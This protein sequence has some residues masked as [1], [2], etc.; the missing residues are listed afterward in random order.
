M[1][2]NHLLEPAF[3]AFFVSLM[4]PLKYWDGLLWLSFPALA[5]WLILRTTQ[6]R[7]R[8]LRLAL[9]ALVCVAGYVLLATLLL[10]LGIGGL[11]LFFLSLLFQE[12]F[13]SQFF[14]IIVAFFT[15]EIVL[16]AFTRLGLLLAGWELGWIAY[17]HT[18]PEGGE[19]NV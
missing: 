6:N 10:F 18:R 8:P 15:S 14:E 16:S 12:S 5:Q 17:T 13:V 9:P 7:F 3:E 4:E 2:M 1:Y 19:Q 11:I